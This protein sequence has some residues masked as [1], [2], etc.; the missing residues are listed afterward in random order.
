MLGPGWSSTSYG[1]QSL[2]CCAF[3]LSAAIRSHACCLAEVFQTFIKRS[4]VAYLNEPVSFAGVCVCM[5][6]HS[7]A[8]TILRSAHTAGRD[9]F[10]YWL[11]N[12]GY[13]FVHTG[14]LLCSRLCLCLLIC[15]AR[16]CRFIVEQPEGS[17]LAN[18]PRFQHI[19]KIGRV[20]W[21]KQYTNMLEF[22][23]SWLFYKSFQFILAYMIDCAIEVFTGSFWMGAFNGNTAKRHRLWSNDQGLLQ[24]IVKQ[25]GFCLTHLNI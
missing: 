1:M 22:H 19:L 11:G 23:C 14:N 2:E 12:D 16:G 21:F 8:C 13:D 17:S 15:F 25:G 24:E 3:S 18:H 6:L 9:V 5:Y 7:C 20:S 10:N 4:G